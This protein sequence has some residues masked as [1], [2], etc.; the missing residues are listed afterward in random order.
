MEI[1]RAAR[2][3]EES[4]RRGGGGVSRVP[5]QIARVLLSLSFPLPF[6]LVSR[7]KGSGGE[8]LPFSPDLGTD[9]SNYGWV[10]FGSLREFTPIFRF[11]RPR[12]NENPSSWFSIN[13]EDNNWIRFKNEG[14][15]I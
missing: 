8:Q 4:K 3:E 9:L 15:N 6:A 2:N 13:R 11:V 12:E 5:S 7:T 10:M 14:Y 1:G